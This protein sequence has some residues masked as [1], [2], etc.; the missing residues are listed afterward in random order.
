MTNTNH[1]NGLGHNHI[2]LQKISTGVEQ[3]A[4]YRFQVLTIKL[5]HASGLQAYAAMKLTKS[6][7]ACSQPCEKMLL[8]FEHDM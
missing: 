1:P 7:K 5:I 8:L 4:W 6:M 2:E 3:S